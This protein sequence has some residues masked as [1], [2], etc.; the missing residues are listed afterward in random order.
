MEDRKLNKEIV[1]LKD[2]FYH[3][4][5]QSHGEYLEFI[6]RK[7]K[8]KFMELYNS[9]PSFEKINKESIRIMLYLNIKHRYVRLHNFGSQ[10]NIFR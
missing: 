5:F 8:E 1:N 4:S 3:M 10:I 6:E 7:G 2:D 9:D